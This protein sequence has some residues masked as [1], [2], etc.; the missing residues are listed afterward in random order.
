MF[1]RRLGA[2]IPL[3]GFYFVRTNLREAGMPLFLR[4][5]GR[6]RK[7]DG[8]CMARRPPSRAAWE[9][10]ISSRAAAH[11]PGPRGSGRSLAR[12]DRMSR[13]EPIVP[14]RAGTGHFKPRRCRMSR[15][16]Q[17]PD[18]SSRAVVGRHGPRGSRS[19]RR[20]TSIA[21]AQVSPKTRAPRAGNFK[22][23][24]FCDSLQYNVSKFVCIENFLRWKRE[25]G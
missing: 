1:P 8:L 13:A 2:E 21:Q 10:D 11:R 25:D 3:L 19:F 17:Q 9:P 20:P 12:R 22:K 24:A 14:G 16:A 5:I 18:I 4:R 7:A 6:R 23:L 15:V